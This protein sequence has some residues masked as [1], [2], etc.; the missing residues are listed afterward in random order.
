M[1]WRVSDEDLA[2]VHP[3]SQQDVHEMM[4]GWR[5]GYIRRYV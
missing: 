5:R 1:Q 2:T 3:L 4:S